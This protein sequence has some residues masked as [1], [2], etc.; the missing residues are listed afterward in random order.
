[1]RPQSLACGL[2][3]S[4]AGLAAWL[5]D[6]VRS[7]S[8]CNGDLESVFPRDELLTVLTIYWITGTI[9]S[10]MRIYYESVRDNPLAQDPD[11]DPR[12]PIV[13]P[14]SPRRSEVP[15]AM[16]QLPVDM[17]PVPR[18][19]VERTAN[20]V[21]WTELPRGGHFGEWEVPDLIARDLCDFFVS[22]GPDFA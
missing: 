14:F 6:K 13:M 20:V 22:L 8:D 5:I 18:E 21:R 4:P 16:A 1:M 15:L 12:L 2:S 3:D 7:W 17:V 10:S 11:R 19:W 9:G